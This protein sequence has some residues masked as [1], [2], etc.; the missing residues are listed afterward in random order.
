MPESN[1][2]ANKQIAR[3]TVFL[4]IRKIATLLIALYTSRI[5]LQTLGIDDFGLYGLLGSI[6]I[7]FNS[8]RGLFASSIQ[9]FLNIEKCSSD[10]R[11][12]RI[13]SMGCTI[14]AG[15]AL[16][17][18]VIVE[19]AGLIMIPNLNLEPEK[20][21]VAYIVL[22]FSIL[23]SIV[24]ILTVPYDALMMAKERFDAIAGFSLLDAFLR[25]LIIYLLTLAP[26]NRLIFYSIL[27]FVVS[28][29]IRLVNA[30]YCK[31]QFPLIAKYMFVRDH[32]LFKEMTKFAGW[33]FFGNLGYSL[34]NQGLNFVLNYFGGVV[35]NA[36]RAIA[37]QVNNNMRSFVV[38]IAVAF[39]PQSMQA[40]FE[41]KTRFYNLQ[42]IS[43][44][45]SSAIFLIFAFPMY[46]LTAPILNLWLG[47]CPEYSVSFIH[48]IFFYSMVRNWHGPIDIA[49]KSANK[50]QAYQ[51][52]EI[53]IMIL[54]LPISCLC[55]HLGTPLYSI[56]VIMTIVEF[57]NMI[58]ILLI[59]KKQIDFPMWNFIKSVV[60]PTCAAIIV[61]IIGYFTFYLFDIEPDSVIN[62]L[63]YCVVLAFIALIVN[64]FVV[65]SSKE[66]KKLFEIIKNKKRS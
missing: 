17:F 60:I 5:L 9:R 20:V 61:F 35:A 50:M 32:S 55:L 16:L 65:F 2:K 13:F 33:N 63:L 66:R 22:Q 58:A 54:N 18:F 53:V 42:F 46:L 6:V 62:L 31:R 38:D 56:F 47:E 44:K 59:A 52:C 29:L 37:Y 1:H 4:Y 34:T 57:I 28:L 51:I 23:A 19:I 25:L 48:G 14:H 30:I 45:A 21:S 10:E 26:T 7:L 64:I 27:V 3:N 8:L 39:T 49:F 15:I 36:A 11:Q 40:Y 41:H 43:A 12:N 24:S